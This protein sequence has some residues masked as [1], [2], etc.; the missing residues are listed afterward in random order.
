M[1]LGLLTSKDFQASAAAL[2]HSSSFCNSKLNFY[3]TTASGLERVLARELT[4]IGAKNV[5]IAKN[6]VYFDGN[7]E[8]LLSSLMNLRTALRVMEKII[9]GSHVASKHDLYSLVSSI[10]WTQYLSSPLATLKCDTTLGRDVSRELT[11]TH[12]CSLTV[13]NAIVDQFRDREGVRPSVDLENPELPL[14]L[15]LHRGTATLYRIWS[16]DS[17]LHKR[18]YRGVVHKA[19]LR[20]TTA[21][22]LLYLSKWDDAATKDETFIDPM[23]GSGTLAIEAALISANVAPGLIRYGHSQERTKQLPCCT[24]WP[25]VGVERWDQIW[26]QAKSRDRREELIELRGKSMPN[27]FVNDAEISCIELAIKAAA[28]AG[29]H[30]LIDFSCRDISNYTPKLKNQ[31]IVNNVVTNPPWDLRIGGA[32]EA[33]FKLGKF[34]KSYSPNSVWAL[35]GNPTVT[36]CID[37]TVKQRFKLKASSVN[38]DYLNFEAS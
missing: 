6:G 28:A 31:R 23:C 19:A 20:E 4:D 33:W 7:T 8:L 35:T 24:R 30:Q 1:M 26:H 9:E 29:V 27:I 32:K 16:G 17:S 5:E 12:F 14:L 3:A 13:K 22:A 38:M 37:L 36:E 18:G 34:V 2:R 15:Y 21:A 25:Q 10:D 11:H